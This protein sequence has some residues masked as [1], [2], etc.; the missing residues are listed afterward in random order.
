MERR[1]ELFHGSSSLG[2]T[3]DHLFFSPYLRSILKKKIPLSF[4]V[5]R[6]LIVLEKKRSPFPYILFSSSLQVVSPVSVP[7]AG[8]LDVK[9]VFLVLA[10]WRLFGARVALVNRAILLVVSAIFFTATLRC[11]WNV[12]SASPFFGGT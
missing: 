9:A 12:V 1:L 3:G 5:D 2:Q 11:R 10:S 7:A 4:P 6:I 8:N